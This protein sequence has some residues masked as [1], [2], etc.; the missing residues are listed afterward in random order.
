MTAP[1]DVDRLLATWFSADAAE[2]APAD[3]FEAITVATATTRRRP[4]WLPVDRRLP[5][6]PKLPM[7][8]RVV[9][10]AAL[11][12]AVAIATLVVVGSRPRVPPPFGP[13]LPGLF[14]MSVDGNIVTSTQDG[15]VTRTLTND[16]AVNTNP[17]FSRD[18]TQ[19]AFWSWAPPSNL[20]ELVV[21]RA[22][23][24]ARRTIARVAFT[25]KT[26]DYL[27]LPD[28]AT[29]RGSSS[30]SSTTVTR[31]SIGP[32]TGASSPTRSPT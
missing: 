23:G 13:A 22:D 18:G 32:R 27:G 15:V 19:L 12:L 11:L 5:A 24:S 9:A 16:D 28:D 17:T 1:H 10:L 6:L 14:A 7:V 25:E 30:R 26:F 29:V 21:M 8:V 3:L 31:R 2:A 20:A 4:G